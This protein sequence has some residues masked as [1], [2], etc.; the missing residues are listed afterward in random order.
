MTKM[1]QDTNE[2]IQSA[3]SNAINHTALFCKPFCC[4]VNEMHPGVWLLSLDSVLL[5]MWQCDMGLQ[6]PQPRKQKE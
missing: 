6:L 3:S 2:P 4:C 5:V 1:N